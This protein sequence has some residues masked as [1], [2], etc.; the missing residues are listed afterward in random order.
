MYQG[1]NSSCVRLLTGRNRARNR[2]L[3]FL[4]W[5]APLRQT[6]ESFERVINEYPVLVYYLP[7]L[8]HWRGCC[9]R[10]KKKNGWR[11]LH[12]NLRYRVSNRTAL[13]FLL[14]LE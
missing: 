12:S 6:F 5:R 10:R 13:Y 2:V 1:R 8:R 4:G 14:E 7:I 9:N 11:K 3:L